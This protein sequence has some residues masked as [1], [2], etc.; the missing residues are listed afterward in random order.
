[1][2]KNLPYLNDEHLN[3]IFDGVY[4]QPASIEETG[5]PIDERISDLANALYAMQRFNYH[6]RPNDT[7]RL[8]DLFNAQFN[9]EL[10]SE[11]AALWL[12]LMLAIQ[13]LYG[14]TDSKLVEVIGQVTI[15]K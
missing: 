10:N 7:R 12:A 9:F 1:M 6:H 15:R 13:E 4:G 5:R 2:K 11:G 8:F 14:F 3:L